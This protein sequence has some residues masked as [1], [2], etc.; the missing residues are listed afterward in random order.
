M[1][2]HQSSENTL[3]VGVEIGAYTEEQQRIDR[4]DNS[5]LDATESN[6][7]EDYD[8]DDY[9]EDDINNVMYIDENGQLSIEAFRAL[10]ARAEELIDTNDEMENQLQYKEQELIR[11]SQSA[12]ETIQSCKE[13]ADK[14]AEI[15]LSK[16]HEEVR[17]RQS[18]EKI[19]I[20][21][22]KQNSKLY[23]KLRSIEIQ[24]M[25]DCMESTNTAVKDMKNASDAIISTLK[26]ELEHEKEARAHELNTTN[27]LVQS[28][29]DSF[30]NN[31]KRC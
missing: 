19:I 3:G 11:L 17:H 12:T 30:D 16:V 20:K 25:R 7:D 8:E 5:E 23:S 28:L 29:L 14:M 31:N 9:D 2:M 13:E 18:L 6:D 10:H 21:L 24:T 22:E 1:E 4:E 15:L 27:A 26:Q